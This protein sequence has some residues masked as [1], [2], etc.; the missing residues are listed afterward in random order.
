MVE[1]ERSYAGG[2]VIAI[3]HRNVARAAH[4]VLQLPPD[5]LAGL[6]VRSGEHLA[7]ILTTVVLG[8]APYEVDT[9]G[10]VDLRFRLADSVPFALLP[11]DKDVAAF[12]IKSMPGPFR[13]FDN[14]IDMTDPA[15]RDTRG[16]T[17]D[18]KVE[19]ANDILASAQP[20]LGRAQESLSRK[21]GP[22]ESQNVFLVIHPFD[23]FAIET[24][25]SPVIAAALAPL[26]VAVDTVWV[27]WVPDHLT[28]W[29]TKSNRW[30][31]LMFTAIRPDE[32]AKRG[33][34]SLSVLQDA[35]S[36]FLTGVGHDAASP[37]LFGL[38]GSDS[39][40]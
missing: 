3:W 36:E 23:R 20:L 40:E 26:N 18:V 12:E 7:A 6:K 9:R 35:E 37:Y 1:D 34:S 8:V 4:T 24:Y 16:L 2:P 38:S 22:N 29:S 11:S 39:D 5:Q 21:A 25:Q 13:K 15:Q 27:L 33:P 28:V 31:D 10:D 14:A 30:T 19:T 17:L 32:S